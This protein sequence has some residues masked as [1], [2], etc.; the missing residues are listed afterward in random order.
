MSGV[1]GKR[2]DKN[3]GGDG[4]SDYTGLTEKG[5]ANGGC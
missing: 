3:G 5:V 1:P 2:R 4:T